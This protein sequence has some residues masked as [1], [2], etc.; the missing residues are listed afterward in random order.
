MWGEISRLANERR[1]ANSKHPDL[2]H[3]QHRQPEDCLLACSLGIVTAM[4]L[5]CMSKI[6]R[7]VGV[8]PFQSRVCSQPS[9]SI[10]APPTTSTLGQVRLHLNWCKRRV[11]TIET[12]VCYHAM[13]FLP[14]LAHPGAGMVGLSRPETL[15]ARGNTGTASHTRWLVYK[16]E[17]P[18]PP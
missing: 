11:T 5:R 3:H 14:M 15:A 4:L 16:H 1:G 18:L 8:M 17:D 9:S 7:T 6:S 10:A 13:C 12:R 2:S